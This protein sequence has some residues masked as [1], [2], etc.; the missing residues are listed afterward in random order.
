[1]KIYKIKKGMLVVHREDQDSEVDYWRS[2]IPDS[3]SVRNFVVAEMHAVPYSIHP[4]IQRTL[5]KV[6]RHFY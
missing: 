3:T 4:G 6:R 1:M 5:Q 2:V